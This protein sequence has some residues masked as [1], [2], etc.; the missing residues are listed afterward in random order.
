MSENM[1]SHVGGSSATR[2]GK[3]SGSPPTSQ[4][5]SNGLRVA[6]V[7]AL[8]LLIGIGLFTAW[9]IG[10]NSASGTGTT[11]TTNQTGPSATSY[12]ALPKAVAATFRQ[13]VV[14]INVVTTQG[15]GLGSGT[16]IDN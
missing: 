11:T 2:S 4:G 12:N 5:L 8:V 7:V 10:R 3:Q 6:L 1:E 15:S 9:Q 13:S 16:I 14:Q